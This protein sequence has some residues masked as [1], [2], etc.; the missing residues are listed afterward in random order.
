MMASYVIGDLHGCYEKFCEL[1]NKIEFCPQKDELILTGDLLSHTQKDGHVLNKIMSLGDS[2]KTVLGNHDI[3]FLSEHYL[4][5]MDKVE[6]ISP[7]TKTHIAWIERSTIIYIHP[8]LQFIVTHAGIPFNWSIDTARTKAVEFDRYI[9]LFGWKK[10]FHILHKY[11]NIYSE[12]PTCVE[13]NIAAIANGFTRMR[14]CD[15]AGNLDFK[16]ICAPGQ[17]GSNLKPWFEIRSKK[18]NNNHLLIFGHWASLGLYK[19]NGV[20]CCDT[21][22]L[23]GGALTALKIHTPHHVSIIQV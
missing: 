11:P 20:I 12:H 16:Y 5:D 22:C 18:Q 8:T 6:H 10:I 2:V 3:K 19:K 7:L 4:H 9:N 23:W 15:E 1:L 14:F 17:Q 13:K 21:G